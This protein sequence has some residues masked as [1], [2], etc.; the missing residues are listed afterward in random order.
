M[1]LRCFLRFDPEWP[2]FCTSRQELLWDETTWVSALRKNSGEFSEGPFSETPRKEYFNYQQMLSPTGSHAELLTC[3]LRKEPT[4]CRSRCIVT[5]IVTTKGLQFNEYFNR[6]YRFNLKE[7]RTHMKTSNIQFNQYADLWHCY[8]E[9][10]SLVAL[11]KYRLNE[12][13]FD[14]SIE[15]A[16]NRLRKNV[17]SGVTR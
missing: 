17:L 3:L 12:S 7:Y 4:T 13:H 10:V 11:N 2:W 16:T 8:L 5:P 9:C 15:L 6:T 1:H 14:R